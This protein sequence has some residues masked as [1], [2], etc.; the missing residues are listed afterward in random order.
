[1]KRF[2]GIL[3]STVSDVTCELTVMVYGCVTLMLLPIWGL[4]P[5]VLFLFV[6]LS[7]DKD[8]PAFALV[9]K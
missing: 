9:Q 8:S 4:C 6:M 3:W 5:I 2:K 1:M 7:H